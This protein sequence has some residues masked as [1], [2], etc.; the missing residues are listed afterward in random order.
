MKVTIHL[1][2][3]NFTDAIRVTLD[4][5]TQEFNDTK[6]KIV[7]DD[8]G[9]G[10]HRL[11]TEFLSKDII[12]KKP[13][14]NPVGRF[15]MNILI[16]ILSIIVHF[17]DSDDVKGPK[18]YNWLTHIN[19]FEFKKSFTVEFK[20]N[21]E[22]SVKYIKPHYNPTIEDF[23]DPDIEINNCTAKE[24][25][26]H[27]KFKHSYVKKAFKIFNIPVYTLIFVI[28]ALLFALFTAIFSRRFAD[29]FTQ[30]ASENVFFIVSML[31][32]FSVLIG[33]AVMAVVAVVRSYRLCRQLCRKHKEINL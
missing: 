1:F 25:Y 24:E 10:R 11:E 9:T 28:I 15:F 3:L 12:E 16:A 20:D 7:F 22:I 30:S 13:V 8:T 27:T 17:I 26:R 4:G 23:S 19:P 5:K 29:I 31:F 2:N 18:I 33:L 21:T 14:K 32:C 6:K